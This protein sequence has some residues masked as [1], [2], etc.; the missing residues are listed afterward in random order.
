MVRETDLGLVL[1]FEILSW[2]QYYLLLYTISM[3]G[4]ISHGSRQPHVTL[5]I[6]HLC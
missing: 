5:S 4:K 6:Y 2:M 1:D 3:H